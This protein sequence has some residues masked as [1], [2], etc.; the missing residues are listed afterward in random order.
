MKVSVNKMRIVLASTSPRR[1]ELMKELN[2]PFEIITKKVDETFYM[3]K[4][5][6][7]LNFNKK[8]AN[9]LS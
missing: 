9:L 2:L 6:D 8:I 5:I 3:D 4:S 1:R 7:T